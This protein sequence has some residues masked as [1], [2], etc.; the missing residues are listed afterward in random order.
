MPPASLSGLPDQEMVDGAAL[1]DLKELIPRTPDPTPHVGVAGRIVGQ[2][3]EDLPDGHGPQGLPGLDDRNGAKEPQ[4]VQ[5]PVRG[6]WLDRAGG[7]HA[8][9][10]LLQGCAAC[11]GGRV[12]SQERD[13]YLDS[14][15]EPVKPY[16]SSANS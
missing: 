10:T 3:L 12:R 6:Q 16:A 4:A 9:P 11:Q 8:K 14:K 13:K 2:H 1:G 7:A 15:V 5:S